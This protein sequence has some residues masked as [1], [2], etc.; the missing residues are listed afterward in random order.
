MHRH[1]ARQTGKWRISSLNPGQTNKHVA[2]EF[3]YSTVLCCHYYMQCTQ[4][5]RRIRELNTTK[6]G[7]H[8]HTHAATWKV[9]EQ[10]S[11]S[12]AKAQKCECGMLL[13]RKI[14]Y[15]P[16]MHRI[17]PEPIAV[18]VL[19]WVWPL[20][21]LAGLFFSITVV[22]VAVHM[23]RMLCLCGIIT[24]VLDAFADVC[25]FVAAAVAAVAV[26]LSVCA[27]ASEI[28]SQG[29]LRNDYT[30]AN[31]NVYVLAQQIIW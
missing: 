10:H 28:K 20:L 31:N 25:F 22:V 16:E 24:V 9:N 7:A 5:I 1:T 26:S 23:H 6:C 21:L 14:I 19:S 27:N 13:L 11:G 4:H 30:A 15:T 29:C 8:T 17:M 18:G 2:N 3:W 12:S